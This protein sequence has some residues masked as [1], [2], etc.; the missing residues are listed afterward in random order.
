MGHLI[1]PISFRL[2]YVRYWN[3]VWNLNFNNYNYSYLNITDYFINLLLIKFFKSYLNSIK[4][5]IIY[6]NVKI[7]R[8]YYKIIYNIF[9][10]D[11]FYDMMISKI[12]KN[13]K[14]FLF[15]RFYYNK[16]KNIFLTKVSLYLNYFIRKLYKKKYKIRFFLKINFNKISKK[17]L[18]NKN[19]KY[20]IYIY[21]SSLIK[22]YLLSYLRR[23]KK[24]IYFHY[25][26]FLK[27]F[28]FFIF[29]KLHNYFWNYIK[30]ILFK[31]FNYIFNKNIKK[32]LNNINIL[33]VSKYFILS[34]IVSD[35]IAIRLSQ[36]F[37]LGEVLSSVNG[38][39]YKLYKR[40]K[41]IKGYKIQCS[42]RFTRK[43]RAML[44]WKLFYSI[45]PSTLKSQLDYS[46][47]EVIL[48]FGKCAIK[49]W[50][51]KSRFSKKRLL[52]KF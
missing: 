33:C 31:Y 10:H 2:Y 35:F 11:S 47:T 30:L 14:K 29:N 49:V 48:K 28:L 21:R 51:R 4:N 40:Y 23:K 36:N 17:L 39:F 13:I 18:L 22:Y 41:L 52:Y 42:G 5:G 3:N 50:I 16:V 32:S 1:N 46:L 8:S 6:L 25:K 44:Q 9:I 45:K 15:P 43:Q 26:L 12:Y 34:K 27:F 38:F 24:R 19:K 37:R 20:Y 7:I